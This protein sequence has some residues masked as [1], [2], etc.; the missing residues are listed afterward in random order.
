MDKSYFTK[1]QEETLLTFKKWEVEK[2]N[3]GE[4]YFIV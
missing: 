4:V 1:F 2:G 3:V